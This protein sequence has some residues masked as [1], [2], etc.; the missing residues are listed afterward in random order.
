MLARAAK[1]EAKNYTEPGGDDVK[2]STCKGIVGE[3]VCGQGGGNVG[4]KTHIV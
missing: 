1:A 2:G 3:W 4:E